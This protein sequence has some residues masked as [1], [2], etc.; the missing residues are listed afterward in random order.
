MNEMYADDA[1]IMKDSTT[2]EDFQE[3]V[4]RRT[5]N[6]HVVNGTKIWN[7]SSYRVDEDALERAVENKLDEDSYVIP[8]QV[9]GVWGYMT[10]TIPESISKGS[11]LVYLQDNE[12]YVVYNNLL[13]EIEDEDIK[14][15]KTE[16][17]NDI[18]SNDN[19]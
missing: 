2:I 17:S 7:F 5:Q 12:E 18:S 8:F 16:L 3:F 4:T 15:L 9:T 13:S 10:H 6:P 11:I 1:L 14:K 19:Q